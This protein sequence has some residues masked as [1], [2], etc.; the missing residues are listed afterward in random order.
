MV[1]DDEGGC[2]PAWGGGGLDGGG[3][4]GGGGG[5]DE[6]DEEDAAV[7]VMEPMASTLLRMKAILHKASFIL[8]ILLSQILLS[9]K[10]L[11]PGLSQLGLVPSSHAGHASM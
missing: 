4:G 8:K 6:E 7:E 1:E 2:A 10:F 9:S 5:V 11:Q 3:G